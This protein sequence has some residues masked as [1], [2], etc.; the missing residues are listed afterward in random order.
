[1]ASLLEYA[2]YAS[3][4]QRETLVDIF[5]RLEQPACE[6]GL[7]LLL[8][9]LETESLRAVIIK[10]LMGLP[11]VSTTLA[12]RLVAYLEH[13]LDLGLRA[14]VV[15]I[16][17]N[18]VRAEP[19]VLQRIIQRL[20]ACQDQTGLLY[21]FRDRLGALPA[22]QES[23]QQL[24]GASNSSALKLAILELLKNT[25]KIAFLA[26]AL[27]DASP[28]VRQKAIDICQGC[29]RLYDLELSRVII[30]RIAEE[31]LAD[32]RRSL[33]KLL[34]K[35]QRKPREVEDFLLEWFFRE[36][37]PQIALEMA[38]NIP[39]VVLT[40]ENQQ[41]LANA[42][43]KI[44][45]EPFYPAALKRL[46][47]RRLQSF[48]FQEHPALLECL[49]E[50]LEQAA[51]LGTVREIYPLLE[52]FEPD[53][54]KHLS[55]IRRLFYR[56]IGAYPTEPLKQWVRDFQSLAPYDA[57]L[58]QEIPYIIKLTG[59]VGL[60]DVVEPEQQQNR[61]VP[62]ILEALRDNQEQE[63][64]RLLEEAYQRRTLGKR[65]VLG[66]Y[67]RLLNYHDR[68][69]LLNGLLRIM[70]EERIGGAEVLDA[71]LRFLS[72]FPDSDAAYGVQCY[73]E[74]VGVTE[75][76]YPEQMRQALSPQNYY[77]YC[78]AHTVP[79]DQNSVPQS[80]ED[81][82]HWR[83]LYPHWPVVELFLAQEP[84]DSL[85]ETLLLPL[86]PK[87]PVLESLQYL[88]LYRIWGKHII[89]EASLGSVGRLMTAA[90]EVP[91]YD[92]LY[93]RVLCTFC[94]F[95]PAY[96]ETIRHQP[97]P[98]QLADYA[99][100]A[101]T[102]QYRRSLQ[103][104]GD[105]V[106]WLPLPLAGV[107]LDWLKVVTDLDWELL[108][109]EYRA[110]LEAE[111]PVTSFGNNRQPLNFLPLRPE[112]AVIRIVRFLVRTGLPGESVWEKPWKE[113]LRQANREHGEVIAR[114]LGELPERERIKLLRLLT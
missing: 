25:E 105:G 2:P 112:E 72:A 33:L 104:P 3:R 36:T 68:Y 46:I 35:L 20:Q 39:E 95:W 102:E 17:Y 12:G 91:G 92:A 64:G 99:A 81:S 106:R 66:L 26:A 71:G 74:Q 9:P 13:E 7:L 45:R 69:P 23:L 51:D 48:A 84:E 94:S 31:P 62:A 86:D 93:D 10:H 61:L 78:L 40:V 77:R 107:N 18:A 42:Y 49:K 111:L 101:F 54:G 67:Q 34:G 47:T 32:L 70:T 109:E 103:Y 96:L 73:L 114:N 87:I 37:N 75:L 57:T 63:A 22:F 85:W 27:A 50:L 82:R 5:S 8:H 89:S 30:N 6:Q 14:Q 24:F 88:L 113:M 65:E 21:A 83:V 4:A 43:L 41:L 56:F 90:R 52:N 44:L 38:G 15:E 76:S 60:L 16:L 55:L 110:C 98:L 28:W 100:S 19:E 53:P 59:E 1:V 108:W 11:L 29:I 97:V 80:W 79:Q 58:R